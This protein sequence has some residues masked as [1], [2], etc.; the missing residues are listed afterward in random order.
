[1]NEKPDIKRAVQ[2]LGVS[3]ETIAKW[4]D[5]GLIRSVRLPSGVISKS[6]SRKELDQRA[7]EGKLYAP[8][9]REIMEAA[10]K[11]CEEEQPEPPTAA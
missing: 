6:P 11:A 2:D 8:F 9:P 5:A 4:H 3:E 7:A 10:L 1:M